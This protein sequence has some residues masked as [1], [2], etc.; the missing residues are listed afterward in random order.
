[1]LVPMLGTQDHLAA[2]N[3]VLFT[4]KWKDG[5]ESTAVITHSLFQ[6]MDALDT[7]EQTTVCALAHPPT[8]V[9]DGRGVPDFALCNPGVF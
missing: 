6:S 8:S 3:K 7:G 1:M 2:V 4:D 9:F 5:I